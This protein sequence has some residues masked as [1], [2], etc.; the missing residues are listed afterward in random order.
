MFH[1]KIFWR[2]HWLRL[3]KHSLWSAHLYWV[4]W[5]I[6]I[7]DFVFLNKKQSYNSI[8]LLHNITKHNFWLELCLATILLKSSLTEAEGA[9]LIGRSACCILFHEW[10]MMSNSRRAGGQGTRLNCQDWITEGWERNEPG[11]RFMS[12]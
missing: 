2:T 1:Q 6:N 9:W 12:N 8:K 5:G 4:S 7:N 11:E 3:K 10:S